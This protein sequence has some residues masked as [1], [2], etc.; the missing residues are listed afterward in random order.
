MIHEKYLKAEY[1]YII[2]H[3]DSIG[4]KTGDVIHIDGKSRFICLLLFMYN[5]TKI[6]IP[7]LPGLV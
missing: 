4:G 6:Y 5:P 7:V 3:I 1:N 2:N